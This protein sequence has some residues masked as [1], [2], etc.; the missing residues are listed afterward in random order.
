M[1][2]NGILGIGTSALLAFQRAL[3]TTGHNVANVNTPGY[4]RQRIDLSAQQPANHLQSFYIGSGVRVDNIR[5]EFD[6]FIENQLRNS[7]TSAEDANVFYS[8]SRRIDNL[9][10]DPATGLTPGINKFF[11]ALQDVA[12]DPTSIPSRQ[13][14]ISE[15]ESLAHRFGFL[16][17]RLNEQREIVEGQ[18]GTNVDEIN[19]LAR[20]VADVN[21][22]IA[23]LR[24]TPG[25]PNDLLDQRDQLIQQL[26][27][28]VSVTLVDQDNGA[29]N[30]F[31]GKGQPLVLGFKNFEL[32]VNRNGPDPRR[33]EVGLKTT[34]GTIQVSGVLDGGR[35]GALLNLRSSVLDEAQN[36]LGRVAVGLANAFNEQHMLGYDLDGNLGQAFFKLPEP[37][38]Q[39]F[40]GN[41]GTGKPVVSID[42]NN[43]ANLTLDDYVLEQAGGNWTLKSMQTG[44]VIDAVAGNFAHVG[45]N[46]DTTGLIATDKFFISPTRNAASQMGVLIKEPRELAAASAATGRSTNLGT[47]VVEGITFPAPFNAEVLPIVIRANVDNTGAIT[48]E[49]SGDPVPTPITPTIDPDTG[50]FIFTNING[51]GINLTLSGTP[52]NGDEF[53]LPHPGEVGDNRNAL[54]LAELQSK[55]FLANGTTSIEADYGNIVAK[56]GTK[57]RQAEITHQAQQRLLA[58]ARTQREEKSG[59]NL[60]EEA[61]NLLRFQQAYQASAQIIAASNTIFDTLIA[62]V[63][64]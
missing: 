55:R 60:D 63:R 8:F 27:E 58:E 29:V 38:V 32:E 53:V 13:V 26:A 35:L 43:L 28:R 23:S 19:Q 16:Q 51:T 14:L 10:A 57:T 7:V 11:A 47:G 61:A 34:G 42:A 41:T 36:N 50:A 39:G 40:R 1:S 25:Q 15:G 64:R 2:N 9:L 31:I 18:I 59:V 22:R 62:A 17:T 56:V 45:L 20:G 12:S 24:G 52:E 3:A 5:R 44:Q 21:E 30:V 37:D 48:F 6:Q 54:M 49:I 4:S 33:P 46:I